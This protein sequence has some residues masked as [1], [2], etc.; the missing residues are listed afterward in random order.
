MKPGFIARVAVGVVIGVGVAIVCGV[1]VGAN[2][3]GNGVGFSVLVGSG[4]VVG[5]MVPLGTET[6]VEMSGEVGSGD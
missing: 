2:G 4:R 1:E 3:V 6:A 5:V